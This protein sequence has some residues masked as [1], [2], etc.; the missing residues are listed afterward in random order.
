M[1]LWDKWHSQGRHSDYESMSLQRIH[2]RVFSEQESCKR[3]VGNVVTAFYPSRVK[4]RREEQHQE[5][6]L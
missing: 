4:E 1:A 5:S 3:L 6:G 2:K